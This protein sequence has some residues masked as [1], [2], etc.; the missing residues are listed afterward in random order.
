MLKSVDIILA[1]DTRQSKKLLAHYDIQTAVTSYHEHNES[2][3]TA[4]II[5]ALHKGKTFALISDA[6]TPLIND[7]GYILVR[8]AKQAGIRVV[9]IPGANAIISA[10]SASAIAT[11]RFR[12]YGFLPST[13]TARQKVIKTIVNCYETII[14]YESPKRILVSLLDLHATL[15]SERTVCLAKELTKSF[16]TIKTAYLPEL[17]NYLQADIAHQ[18][19]EFVLIIAPIDKKIRIKDEEQLDKVLAVLLSEMG[20]SKAAKLA[21]KITN[22]DKKY[23]YQKAIK[24]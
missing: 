14:F 20:A 21:A 2:Q 22:I 19:G 7:P 18:K 10:L 5:S 6:G 17:I 13:Q 16:E 4:K 23:C 1:E 11:N 3:K 15:G 8:N 9:P 12:F 24:Q